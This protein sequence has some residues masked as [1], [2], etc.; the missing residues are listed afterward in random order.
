MNMN[1]NIVWLQYCYSCNRGHF[2]KMTKCPSCDGKG[3]HIPQPAS[4]KV[5]D[6][7]NANYECDGCRAYRNHTIV[8]IL[9]GK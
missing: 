7:C 2:V 6:K 8:G 5:Y 3:G 9:K 1:K 4:N